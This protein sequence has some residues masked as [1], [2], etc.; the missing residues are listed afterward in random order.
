MPQSMVSNNFRLC[1][2]VALVLITFIGFILSNQGLFAGSKQPKLANEIRAGP[3]EV[4]AIKGE[5]AVSP[6]KEEDKYKEGRETLND[7]KTFRRVPKWVRACDKITSNEEEL[8]DL[9]HPIFREPSGKNHSKRSTDLQPKVI[10]ETRTPEEIKEEIRL[11]NV[12]RVEREK[13]EKFES[14][15]GHLVNK[16]DLKKL[17][18]NIFADDLRVS[19]HINNALNTATGVREMLIPIEQWIELEQKAYYQFNTYLQL[20]NETMM[21]SVEAM[22]SWVP[23]VAENLAN[24][25]KRDYRTTLLLNNISKHLQLFSSLIEQANHDQKFLFKKMRFYI[26]L[27]RLVIKMICDIKILQAFLSSLEHS[28]T[29]FLGI[30]KSSHFQG[31]NE[32]DWELLKR[33]NLSHIDSMELRLQYRNKVL[34]A[35]SLSKDK[36]FVTDSTGGVY[37]LGSEKFE[38]T[39]A[40]AQPDFIFVSRDIVPIELRS[41]EWKSETN[42]RD[43]VVFK[44][45]DSVLQY[46]EKTLIDIYANLK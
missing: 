19:W 7:M 43:R 20:N 18:S 27:E 22:L 41:L 37:E 26:R 46:Y 38:P 6:V 25:E 36:M 42:H 14:L 16:T 9:P 24:N 44:L 4:A 32:S 5:K 1:I 29:E 28:K 2:L 3:Q 39:L 10:P 21:K 33:V 15:I 11:A 8:R 30:L 35:P 31:A 40:S 13:Q 34:E 17:A 23:R 12:I 45:L